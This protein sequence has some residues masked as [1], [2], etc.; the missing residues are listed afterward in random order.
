MGKIPSIKGDLGIT[1]KELLIALELYYRTITIGF[2]DE[3][4]QMMIEKK[5]DS[6][7]KKLDDEK[8]K[9]T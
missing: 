4:A 5:I 6:C 7:L 8:K 2:N 3:Y 1:D 9:K